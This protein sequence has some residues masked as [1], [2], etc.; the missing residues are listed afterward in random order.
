MPIDDSVR[1]HYDKLTPM[2]FTLADPGPR[3]MF[4]DRVY[5]RGA[6]TLHALRRSVG[7]TVFFNTVRDYVAANADGIVDTQ[8]LIDAFARNGADAAQVTGILDA[9]VQHAE[10]PECP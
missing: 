6:I 1:T 4:D 10:L 9:W 3:D 8:T 5:K 2:R 7:D